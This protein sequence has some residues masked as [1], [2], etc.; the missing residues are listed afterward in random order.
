MQ[1]LGQ[2]PQSLQQPRK[3][4]VY[5]ECQLSCWAQHALPFVSQLE[6]AATHSVGSVARSAVFCNSP[7]LPCSTQK[8]FSI[9]KSKELRC[10]QSS[11]AVSDEMASSTAIR[12]ATEGGCLLRKGRVQPSTHKAPC[13]LVLG[14]SNPSKTDPEA[15]PYILRAQTPVL[16]WLF[17]QLFRANPFLKN[18]AIMQK[19]ENTGTHRCA[20]GT[21]K[22]VRNK[23]AHQPTMR[24]LPRASFSGHLLFGDCR[25]Q[26]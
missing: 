2:T 25:V 19:R 23:S 16:R 4:L 13:L 22:T 6:A 5:R 11:P 18:C 9:S 21:T 10:S 26:A 15:K 14:C 17:A 8:H 12:S 3:S 7:V 1:G 24:Q 20:Q